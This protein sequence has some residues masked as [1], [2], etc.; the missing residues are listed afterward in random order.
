[1][2]IF[3]AYDI[4][5]LAP[6]ELT[7][8]IAYRV[9]RALV[10]IA[11]G[12]LVVVGRDARATSGALFDSLTRGLFESGSDVISIGICSTPLLY[13]AMN[14]FDAD[15]SVMITASHNPAPWNGLKLTRRGPAP[16]G[17]GSGMEEIERLVTENKFVDAP[18]AGAL[19]EENVLNEY[20]KKVFSIVPTEKISGRTERGG[21]ERPLKIIV[22][23]GNGMAGV[24]ARPLFSQMSAQITEMFFE[25]DCSFPNH[26]ANPLKEETLNALRARVKAEG[27]DLGVA[28]DGD[29]DRVGF[30]DE[31]GEIVR[32]DLIAAILAG[33]VLE[34]HPGG[35]IL[36]DLRSSNVVPEAVMA[37][38]GE[39]L[40]SRVGHAFIKNQM[41]ESGAV[42]GGEFSMHY[43][44]KDFFKMECAD[45]AVLY[46][47]R[48]LGRVGQPLSEI[49]APLKKYAHSGEINFAVRDNEEVLRVLRDH[50]EA[51]AQKVVTIDGRRF[52]F[53]NWWFNVRPSNT[54][55]YLR[56]VM[57]A[58]T[59]EV[60]GARLAELKK[61][62]GSV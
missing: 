3:K 33:E 23:A 45:A 24:T 20:L 41:R 48:L 27:A 12:R 42:F 46:L 29:G 9:G 36:Y 2:S 62:I 14:H 54:E 40:M 53:G 57:E 8:E 6:L 60:L 55:S 18:V 49:V 39:P 4:R 47:L 28:Y 11:D 51:L 21:A 35:K 17:Q 26:E 50:Y 1:M 43:Y 61:I 19:R 58:D 56:L 38:G 7:P 31:R 15:A 30:V 10:K 22:D 32:G 52:N 59:E 44:F 37:A 34:D 5:G 25:P 13:F 16:I